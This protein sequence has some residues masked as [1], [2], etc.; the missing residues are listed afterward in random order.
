[1]VVM[2]FLEQLNITKDKAKLITKSFF[3]ML[4]SFIQEKLK[5]V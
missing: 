1:L 2:F 4:S 5:G 3:D